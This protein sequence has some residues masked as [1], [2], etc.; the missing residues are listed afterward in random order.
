MLAYRHQFHAGNFADVFKHALLARLL[1][2][3]RRKD[4]PFLYLDTH[5]GAGLYDLEHPWAKKNAEYRAGIGRIFGSED[6][7]PLA[8][9]YLEAVRAENPDGRLRRYP[10]SPLIARGLL[11][12]GDR[13]ILSELNK[14]DCAQLEALFARDRRVVVR[15]MDGYQSLKAHLPPKERRG[16]VL[17]D[18]SFDRKHEFER[19]SEALRTA[20]ERWATG[21]YAV[22][23]PFMEPAAMR[24]FERRIAACGVRRILWLDLRLGEESTG[25]RLDGCGM[26]VVNSPYGFAEEAASL[27]DWLR[28][29]LGSKGKGRA[30]CRVLVGE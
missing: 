26:V 30:H 28:R 12:A 21:V 13:A 11:R 15:L 19:L 2:A 1:L 24:D 23:F 4:K 20:H 3:L 6:V 18:S 5:A 14:K 25:E 17:I 16:L 8:A 10:G 9:P 27:L 22:W 7:P 29:V